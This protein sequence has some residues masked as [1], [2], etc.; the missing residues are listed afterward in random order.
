M[1]TRSPLL[2][3]APLRKRIAYQSYNLSE[4][5]FRSDRIANLLLDNADQ[6]SDV[7]EK[8]TIQSIIAAHKAGTD[9]SRTLAF[10][11]MIVVWKMEVE[12]AVATP[13]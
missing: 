4:S 10:L 11:L 9:R 13:S 7:I 8:R 6:V 5:W 12:K 2:Y 3:W 1:L